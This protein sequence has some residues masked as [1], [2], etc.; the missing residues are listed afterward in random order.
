MLKLFL[1][2]S[3][4]KCCVFRKIG[5]S[6]QPV[7]LLPARRGSPALV[8]VEFWKFQPIRSR[9]EP[10]IFKN[11]SDRE[12]S[13]KKTLTSVFKFFFKPLPTTKFHKTTVQNI[14]NFATFLNL[15]GDFWEI[16][17]QHNNNNTKTQALN[18]IKV[19]SQ[20]V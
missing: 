16:F 6:Q 14:E 11:S 12:N 4:W 19:C 3:L 5:S 13:F 18:T 10:P 7:L 2:F 8:A 20:L 1:L 9:V 15:S 17:L